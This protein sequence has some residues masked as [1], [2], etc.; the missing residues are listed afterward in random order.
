MSASAQAIA[1]ID[2]TNS[3]SAQ[4][5]LNELIRDM[6]LLLAR[7]NST[8]PD[9]GHDLPLP[10]IFETA[11]L[12]R[13]LRETLPG[14]I[15][16]LVTP[17]FVA[18]RGAGLAALKPH[19][20]VAK[21]NCVEMTTVVEEALSEGIRFPLWIQQRWELLCPGLKQIFASGK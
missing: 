6:K 21:V 3:I 19:L 7:I 4:G 17:V 8:V 13:Q 5:H 20:V 10:T 15:D 2:A 16:H 11:N 12:A 9:G 1:T 14:F 18:N